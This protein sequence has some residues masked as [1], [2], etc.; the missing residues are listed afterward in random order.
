[1]TRP[2]VPVTVIS[3]YLGAG[4]TTLVNRLLAD[5]QGRRITVLVNDFGEIA[6]DEALILNRSG[7]TIA[8]A[9]GCMCC[10]VGGGVYEAIDKILRAPALPDHIVIETS[11]V[12]D[13]A[14]I[15]QIAVAE[16]DLVSYG[17]VTLIDAFNLEAQLADPL[18]A[19]TVERQIAGAALLVLSKADLCDAAA[20][21]GV[22]A[23]VEAG[24]ACHRSHRT[25]PR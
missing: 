12:A 10:S 6:I 14:K 13:P 4:K 11:G 23:Q 2:P 22:E 18:L 15:E 3:G 9:N 5:A 20:L 24:W 19:D 17:V 25:H 7:D 16:P 8:L 1:M 21:S